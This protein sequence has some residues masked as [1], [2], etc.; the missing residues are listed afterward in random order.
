M[1]AHPS[2]QIEQKSAHQTSFLRQYI[3]QEW[4]RWAWRLTTVTYFYKES[5]YK[6][7]I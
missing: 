6:D 3:V 5:I 1:I 4:A 2:A 7:K